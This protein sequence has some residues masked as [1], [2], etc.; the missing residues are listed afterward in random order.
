MVRRGIV[1]HRLGQTPLFFQP[2]V[3]FLIEFARDVGTKN[4]R[5]TRRLASSQVTTLA[6]FSQ[7]SNELV[8]RGSGHAQPGQSKPSGWLIDKS[9]LA[10]AVARKAPQPP[11]GGLYGANIGVSAGSRSGISAGEERRREGAH[12][13]SPRSG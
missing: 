5:V 4:S 8:W 6:P 3:A 10:F 1:A 11:A 9:A 12:V 13:C 2:I 7:N